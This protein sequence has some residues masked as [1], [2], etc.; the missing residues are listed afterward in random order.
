MNYG[1]SL[2]LVV[3][4]ASVN[5]LVASAIDMYLP[6]FPAIAN[7]LSINSAQVQQ[8]LSVF[9]IG[10]AVGQGIYGPLLDR[11]GRR[12]PL[13]CGVALFVL[14]SVLAALAE[15]LTALLLAR[16]IQAVG[17]AAGSTTPRAVIADICD[18]Q[19]AARAFSMLMQLTLIAPIGAP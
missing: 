12:T 15:S 4:L 18:T 6:A 3:L 5:V 2:S 13:L 16:F 9:L 19:S 1:I 17:A 8:T 14:G 11:F 10:L 7:E